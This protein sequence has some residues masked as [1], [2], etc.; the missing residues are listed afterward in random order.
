MT[1]MSSFHNASVHS[2]QC[3]LC[4]VD[5]AGNKILDTTEIVLR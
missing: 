2:R 1:Q 4:A 3:T 5:N